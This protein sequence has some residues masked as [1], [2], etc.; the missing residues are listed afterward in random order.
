MD[1]RP[2]INFWIIEWTN[3]EWYQ[4]INFLMP[5]LKAPIPISICV[6]ICISI[7]VCWS[8]SAPW[9]KR[10]A[11]GGDT[12][13]ARAH[14][15]SRGENLGHSCWVCAPK[16]AQACPAAKRGKNARSQTRCNCFHTVSHSF[17]AILQLSIFHTI[18]TKVLQK[19]VKSN[20]ISCFSLITCIWNCL[21]SHFGFA[22]WT[23]LRATWCLQWLKSSDPKKSR[24][25]LNE[26]G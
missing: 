21:S 8:K 22:N 13:E 25:W 11:D 2:S 12:N 14:L 18:A 7:C 15:F 1:L 23:G 17:V 4:G 24:L 20:W 19:P 26:A 5:Q 6:C 3:V 10:W 9:T 16:L